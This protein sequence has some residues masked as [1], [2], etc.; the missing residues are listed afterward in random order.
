MFGCAARK[1][2]RKDSWSVRGDPCCL[3]IGDGDGVA[4]GSFL[5]VS[6]LDGFV[7]LYDLRR[8]ECSKY[9][10]ETE[11]GENCLFSFTVRVIPSL[12]SVCEP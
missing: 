3:A 10:D 7:R 6:S 8:L 1:P 9:I 11:C 12:Q 2:Q 4:S 5:F